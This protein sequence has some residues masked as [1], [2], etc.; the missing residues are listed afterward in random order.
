MAAYGLDLYAA[1]CYPV[2]KA[3][4]LKMQGGLREGAELDYD[5]DELAMT[6]YLKNNQAG[7]TVGACPQRY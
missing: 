1:L 6:A 3:I 4:I 5:Y 7:H 2:T